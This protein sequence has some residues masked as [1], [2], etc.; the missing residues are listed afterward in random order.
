MSANNLRQYRERSMLCK[1]ELARKAGLSS[2]TAHRVESGRA[3]RP[4]TKRMILLALGVAVS[5]WDKL[6][7]SA[8]EAVRPEVAE[9]LQVSIRRDHLFAKR[10]A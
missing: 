9:Q 3:C 6:F 5:D 2:L 1:S 4:R 8:S 7:G 10:P